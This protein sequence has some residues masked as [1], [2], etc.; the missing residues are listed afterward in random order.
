MKSE[1]VSIEDIAKVLNTSIATVSRALNNKPGVGKATRQKVLDTA[2]AMGYKP[3]VLA[4][5][6]RTKAINLLVVFPNKD[7]NAEFYTDLLW[8]GYQGGKRFFR[9]Y[10]VNFHEFYLPGTLEDAN[11]K[12]LEGVQKLCEDGC[13]FDGALVYHAGPNA[14]LV[15]LLNELHERHVP[16]VALHKHVPALKFDTLVTDEARVI[17]ELAAELTCKFQPKQQTI[18]VIEN[19]FAETIGRDDTGIGFKEQIRRLYPYATLVTLEQFDP[20]LTTKALAVMERPDTTAVFGTTAR[21]SAMLGEL[22][23]ANDWNDRFFFI[24]AGRNR[25]S[26]RLLQNHVGKCIVDNSPLKEGER[27]MEELFD[28]VVAKKTPE[29]LIEVPLGIYFNANL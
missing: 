26:E 11:Q 19:T 9:D 7:D 12:T 23:A 14:A 20:E 24:G 1:R 25:I 4:S 18:L 6:I 13:V 21:S 15:E 28:L 2:A 22:I 10:A 8:R 16:I 29:E 17:G 3:N 5:G 27:A